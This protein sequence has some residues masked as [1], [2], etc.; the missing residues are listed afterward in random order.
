M[1][2]AF[3]RG[4][5][6]LDPIL[7]A[8]PNYVGTVVTLVGGERFRGFLREINLPGEEF[9]CRFRF[10]RSVSRADQSLNTQAVAI[11][12]QGVQSE[13]QP[14][15]ATV[16]RAGQLSLRVCGALVGGVAPLIPME[17]DRRISGVSITRVLWPVLGL[18]TFQARPGIDQ[19]SIDREVG[20]AGPSVLTSHSHDAG[21]KQFSGL[22]G[23]QTLLILG[24]GAVIP[25]RIHK[26]QIEEPAKQEIVFQRFDQQSFA[27]N[28]E[29]GLENLG[30]EQ[31]LGRDRGA[32]FARV[33][34][35]EERGQVLEGGVHQDLDTAQRMVL[36]HPAL[37][38]NQAEHI[39]LRIN[40]STH[41]I[42]T[43]NE[44]HDSLES[45]GFSMN[46]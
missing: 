31:P 25:D 34:L 2:P 29:E 27:A 32:T 12:H 30:L 26:A 5:V 21:E 38:R 43:N 20:L 22:V 42:Q 35:I 10:R 7:A 36:R 11:L 4:H 15:L 14:G 46:C 3:H 40:S 18:E 37:R 23:Q 45:S 13:A 28:G 44:N 6:G 8:E 19:G 16:A 24:E 39:G 9:G 1:V 33:H 17:V 41:S